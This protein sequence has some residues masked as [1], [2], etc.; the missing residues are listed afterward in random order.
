MTIRVITSF[1]E[2]Y[3]QRIGRDCVESW[4]R[5]WPQDLRLTCYVENFRMP[6]HARIN[7][8]DFDNLCDGYRTFQ[9]SDARPRVKTFAKKAYSVMHAME[10]LDCDRLVWIDADTITTASVNESDIMGLCQQEVCATFMGVYHHLD[11]HDP[12]SPLMFSAETGLFILNKR[13]PQFRQFS[14]RYRK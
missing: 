14:T 8:I 13:H 4:L 9:A 2:D 11:K 12:A 1:N 5:Y 6:E 10:Q 3:Y 7:Q